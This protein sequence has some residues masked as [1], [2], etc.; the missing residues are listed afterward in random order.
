MAWIVGSV[1]ALGS[2][3]HAIVGSIELFYAIRLGGEVGYDQ[4]FANLGIA[5]AANLVGGL[6]LV[7]FARSA[8][9]FGASSGR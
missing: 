9:A 7:T 5:I 1:L 6:A 8:Q 3:N 4:L 2:F